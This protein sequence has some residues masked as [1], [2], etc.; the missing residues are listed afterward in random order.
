MN[1]SLNTAEP[2]R[3]CRWF[4]CRR[5]DSD[6]I[7]GL[8]YIFQTPCAHRVRDMARRASLGIRKLERS[9]IIPETNSGSATLESLLIIPIELPSGM[10]HAGSINTCFNNFPVELAISR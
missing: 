3:C 1:R 4:G 8:Y 6:C 2:E 10:R 7:S 5:R 9:E